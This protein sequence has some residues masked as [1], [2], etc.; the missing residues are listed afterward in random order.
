MTK[1]KK[2]SYPEVCTGAII[3]NNREELFLI[4][5]PKYHDQWII[6]GGHVE[7]G[8]TFEQALVREIKE[9]T[10]MDIYDIRYL[11]TSDHLYEENISTDKH[12]VFV[13]FTC[14]AKNDDVRLD[15]LEAV[16]YIWIRPMD[17]IKLDRIG[18]STK[19]II[20][21]YMKNEQYAFLDEF[22]KLYDIESELREKC[23]WDKEQTID[24]MLND[25]LE[26]SEEVK[27]AIEKKD[28]E[29]LSEELGDLIQTILLIVKIGEEKGKLNLKKIL[30]DVIDK[31]VR[32]HPHVFGELKDKNLTSEQVLKNW[33]EQKKKEKKR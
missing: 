29:N 18:H 5:S 17:A 31:M 22:K 15:N 13:D 12:Y 8:E 10:G 14:R 19:H 26:E 11:D 21:I 2:S 20:E 27:Q 1:L 24:S 23:P 4:K 28:D 6:P 7:L 33:H 30:A 25:L 3:F 16:E 32:R 9:E